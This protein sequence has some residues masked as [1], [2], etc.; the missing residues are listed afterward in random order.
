MKK[1]VMGGVAV[2]LLMMTSAPVQAFG[3]HRDSGCCEITPCCKPCVTY[4]DKVVTCCKPEWKE[5]DVT[6]TINRIVP[7]VVVTPVKQTI[8]VPVWSEQKKMVTCYNQVPRQ[9]EKEI[10]CC[11]SVPVCCTDPCTGCKRTCC[12]TETYTQKVTCTVYDCVPVQKE[13]T[14]KVCSY[15]TEER[16]VECRRVVCEC[17]PETVNRKERYCVMVPYQTTIKVP[18]CT[19][20]PACAP[21]PTCCKTCCATTCCNTCNHGCNGGHHRLCHR[22]RGS[23]GCCN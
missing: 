7:K 15:K 16:T 8:C 20:A 9:V 1:V 14:C 12:K 19:P 17:V 10:C 18:V 2:C 5:R 13:V 3:R 6:C 23:R 4:V 11:R 22:D 21:A